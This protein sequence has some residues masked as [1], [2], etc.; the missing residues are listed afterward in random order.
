MKLRRPSRLDRLH[1]APQT[2]LFVLALSQ[3]AMMPALG[4]ADEQVR[5]DYLLHCSGCHL[6]EGQGASPIPGLQGDPGRLAHTQAG[7]AYLVQVPGASQT[8]ITDK[9][10]ADITNWILQEFS[11][12]TL[13]ADFKPFSAKEVRDARAEIL[14]DPLKRR[15][16]I[17]SELPQSP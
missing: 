1:A 3:W 4:H 13:P 17:W 12:A 14:L 8:P 5:L 16:E 6:P 9:Q 11:S 15:A 7:R 2:A 10:L